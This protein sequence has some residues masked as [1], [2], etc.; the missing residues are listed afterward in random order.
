MNAEAGMR[1]EQRLSLITLGVSDL[2]RS[3]R[4]YREVLGWI[5]S[6]VG[7][8]AV[9]FFPLNGMVLALFPRDALAADAGVGG[10]EPAASSSV[11]LAYNVR[12][13]GEVDDALAQLREAGARVVK[14]AED[15][16]WG[17]RSGYFADPDGFLWEVAWNPGFPMREDGSIQVPE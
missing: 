11:A 13:R 15:A 2:K 5:P 17:G 1:F 12:E 8:D 7:G 10:L 14:P 4:F 6:P 9:T 3:T 16:P